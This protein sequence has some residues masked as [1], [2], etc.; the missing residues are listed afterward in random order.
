ML[1]LIGYNDS[2]L[3]AAVDLVYRSA[4][5]LPGKND[6]YITSHNI[7]CL[8][9]GMSIYSI[10]EPYRLFI[11]RLISEFGWRTTKREVM[12]AT[13]DI[14]KL[15]GGR[16]YRHHLYDSGIST[17]SEIVTLMNGILPYPATYY[18]TIPKPHTR[19]QKRVEIPLSELLLEI[20]LVL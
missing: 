12:V 3:F 9:L 14:V 17:R 16:L 8:L 19:Y 18:A 6:R 20:T 11:R 7:A 15:L 10:H 5:L 13:V 4:V 2:L 1:P